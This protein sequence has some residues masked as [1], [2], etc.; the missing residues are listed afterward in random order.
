M[1]AVLVLAAA[2]CAAMCCD[3]PTAAPA[4]AQQPTVAVAAAIHGQVRLRGSLPALEPL[5]VQND[6]GVCGATR[7]NRWLRVD[8]SHGV[9]DA[10]VYL[11][12]VPAEQSTLSSETVNI[13][14]VQCELAP[15][16]RIIQPGTTV[17]LRNSDPIFHS[18][19]LRVAGTKL[20]PFGA[21]LL[22]AGKPYTPPTT[23][24]YEPRF[25]E[26]ECTDGHPLE[27]GYLIVAAHRWYAI[28]GADGS[29]ALDGVPPGRH[30][31]VVWHPGWTFTIHQPDGL[32]RFAPHEVRAEVTVAARGTATIALDLP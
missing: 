22:P 9:A 14:H 30:T 32:G 7:P 2:S 16:L 18:T 13:D 31:I 21:G 24:L 10:V 12:D 26:L 17:V 1:R 3:P 23:R 27:R 4:R 19:R 6:Q 28:T 20:L 25:Y 11:A 5:P 15:H 29:F 8:A